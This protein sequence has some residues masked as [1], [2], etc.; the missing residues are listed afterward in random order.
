MKKAIICI[1]FVG[2]LISCAGG[3]SGSNP[4]PP[5]PPPVF[6]SL[7]PSYLTIPAGGPFTLSSTWVGAISYQ[8][9]CSIDRIHWQN[10]V[11]GGT[12][13]NY[14]SSVYYGANYTEYYFRVTAT[15]PYGS[16]TSATTA[17]VVIYTP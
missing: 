4:T 14:S 8:W 2:L 11:N 5:P 1:S 15:N 16:T 9:E 12:L 10:A 3:Q 17:T 6:E 13:Q 7:T